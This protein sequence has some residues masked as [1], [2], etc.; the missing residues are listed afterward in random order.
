MA[1][2]IGT[3]SGVCMSSI[4][5]RVERLLYGRDYKYLERRL[6]PVLWAR[7]EASICPAL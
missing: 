3:C 2:S 1:G 6:C 4:M 7:E 5:G